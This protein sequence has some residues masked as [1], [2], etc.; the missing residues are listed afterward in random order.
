MPL[1]LFVITGI[2]HSAD[3]IILKNKAVIEGKIIKE[4]ADQIIIE[5]ADGK[6]T[7]GIL[8][9]DIL[10]ITM[11]KP[12]FFLKGEEAFRKRKFEEAIKLYNEVISR[13]GT[14]EW[15]E[16]ALVEV[17]QAY[18]GLKK[19]DKA[20]RTFE[21]FLSK[22]KDSDLSC[23]V[24]LILGKIYKDKGTYDKAKIFFGEILK[25]NYTGK[26]LAEAQ[27]CLGE[28]YAAT[29]QYEEALMNFLRVVVVFYKEKKIVEDAMFK[30]GCCYE[31]LEDFI[32][33]REI[34]EELLNKY[35]KGKYVKEAG[36]KII[37]MDNKLRKEK[38]DEEDSFFACADFDWR[39]SSGTGRKG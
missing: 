36:E 11:E 22:H 1:C 14:T 35:P 25:E 23:E 18:M 30:S 9:S 31:K 33:A 24:A 6:G 15:A 10:K 4:K 29:E 5:L 7:M 19:A 38:K 39:S 17:G 2:S 32:N 13:Y 26:H 28:I 8:R 37:E 34:Y 27:F 12:E 20:C 3:K 21:R 16:K